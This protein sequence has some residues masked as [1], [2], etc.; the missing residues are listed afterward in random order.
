M[1]IARANFRRARGQTTA[2]ALLV[3]LA[4]L[5][6][7]L[8]LMLS[9]DYKQNFDRYH[10]KLNGEH[11]TLALNDSREEVREFISELLKKDE[12]VEEYCLDDSFFMVGSFAY[13]KGEVNTELIIL[14][15]ETALNRPV[16][17][18]EIV[19]D[20]GGESG[21]YL[22]MLYG[23]D[24]SLSAGETIELTVGNQI[25]TYKVC[26]FL[27]SVM[28]G[29]HNCAMSALVLTEDQ[30]K[31]LE[32]EGGLLKSTLVSVRL[33]DKRESQEFEADLKETVSARYPEIRA[34]SN[35]YE[36][37]SSSRYISQMICSGIVS[38]MAFLVTMIAL[39]VIASNVINYI[40]ENMKNLGALKAVGYE[41]RQI[42][43]ALLFQFSGITL[44]AAL[45]GIGFSYCLFPAVN[46]MMISQT[47]IPYAVHFLPVPFLVTISSIVG[48]VSV[49]V[50]LSARRIRKIEPIT[51]LRE[52][53]L[54][55]NFRKNRIPL[56][57]TRFPLNGAL[58]LKT[59]FSGVK[60][61]V[62]V[63]ITMLVLS[64]VLVFSGLMVENM[65]ADMTPFIHMI[66]G[67]TADSCINVR[68]EAEEEFLR[69]MK[70]DERVEK[71][72][73][74]NT[75]D[76]LH[77]G[78]IGLM[79]SVTDDFSDINNQDMCVEGRYPKYDNEVAI[80]VKYARERGL[81]IGDEITM[82]AE[83][84]EV[85]YLICGYSQISNNLGRDCMFTRKGYERM[86][87][88]QNASYY[89]NLADEVEVET[90]QE[91]TGEWL[92]EDMN[93]A[94]NILDVVEGAGRVYVSLMTVIVIAILILSGA[95]ILFVL[96]LLVRSMLARK[97][98]DYGILKAL[99]FTTGQIIL[100]TALS[101]M[102]AVVLS[103]AVGLAVSTQVI[104]PLTALFLQG[105]GIVKCTF[106]VPL[107]FTVVS[108]VCLCLL[109]FGIA[110]LL[111]LKIRKIVPKELL[112]G[113]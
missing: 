13:H 91:E 79:A 34:Q 22:P 45:P 31:E 24:D 35:S 44:A 50:W 111:S 82:A 75:M 71:V 80:A 108:G 105:I 37:V 60:Q 83:G 103:A 67:E 64:L 54:T 11:V 53:I 69:R 97:K 61:N 14:D 110:C 66:V 36:L 4:A 17:T 30:Y 1:L 33:H 72:Y 23:S 77:V 102:P 90:F 32:G 89:I 18:I 49:T 15:K 20:G 98:R 113:E 85:K 57:R 3:L 76:A 62:T 104:N 25:K 38:A 8:W 2:I 42:I 92:G 88:L 9:M 41:S 39:V 107:G 96:Y 94:I 112:N 73:L 21:V 109:A 86:G 6:L 63:C 46:G 12:R 19:E 59:T 43:G 84:K 5:M 101:F 95:V 106:R 29:S 28:A 10:H 100:Q 55:H 27:N 26:G 74:F 16:G 99:G 70:A 58:A 51:A 68:V 93:A 48:S 52:G 7:N 47:G 65:I 81:D 87:T 78:G 56:E 40:Q